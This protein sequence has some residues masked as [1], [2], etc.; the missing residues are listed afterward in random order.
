MLFKEQSRKEERLEIAS[1]SNRY[2]GWA[3]AIGTGLALSPIHNRWLTDLTTTDGGETLLFLP[4]L[5][6]LVLIMATCLFLLNHWDALKSV[7][8]GDKRIVIPMLVI[9]ISIGLSGITADGWNNKV[10][11]LGMGLFLFAAYLAS[12]VLGKELFKPLAIGAGIA[13]LGVIAYNLV[14]F[15]VVAKLWVFD[16]SVIT[17]GYMFENNY[18][19]LV[20]YVVLGAV[21]AMWKW[22]WA[23]VSLCLVGLFLSG[24][25]EGVFAVGV[26]GAVVLLRRDWG[27][28]LVLTLVP[29]IVVAI[30]LFAFGYGQEKYDYVWQIIANEPTIESSTGKPLPNHDV[31]KDTAQ[32]VP[33]R[34]IE[35]GVSTLGYR[36]QVIKHSLSNIKPF[37]E[38][39]NLTDF[40]KAPNVHN[41][42]LVLIQQL[43]Y[44]GILAALAWSWVSIYCLVRT[45]WKYAW[46]A[47]IFALS[48]F[49]HYVW[50]QLAPLWP[51]I[52]GA[53]TTDSIANDYIFKEV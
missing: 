19:I 30:T 25:P 44:P 18:D 1:M 32:V 27:K 46:V 33:D 21:L 9:V 49:D 39:Y 36:I 52:V 17:G 40:G 41:V 45:R 6:Y 15:D 22:Q 2:R 31:L 28:R 13:C 23:L 10:A 11:P 43:G 53:S 35:D 14:H 51:T 34:D 20:G 24:S 12:R 3:V 50:S 47:I 42:P 37:G 38:G 26:I 5:G 4:Q 8:W 7:G 16:P 29:V 48:P